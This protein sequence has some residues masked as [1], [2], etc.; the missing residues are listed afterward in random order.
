MGR[1]KALS[2]DKA[3]QLLATAQTTE[4]TS[5]L[6]QLSII[7]EVYFLQSSTSGLSDVLQKIKKLNLRTGTT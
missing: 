4:F 1:S 6:A 3:G 5:M 2:S 7:N